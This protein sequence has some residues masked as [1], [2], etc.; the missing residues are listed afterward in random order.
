MHNIIFGLYFFYSVLWLGQPIGAVNGN[1]DYKEYAQVLENHVNQR[2]EV[3]YEKLSS[4]S[5]ELYSFLKVLRELRTAE[6]DAWSEEQK[7]AFWINAYN[8]FTLK[9]II[10]HYPIKSSMIRSISYPKNSIRQIPGVWKKIKFFAMGQEFTLNQIEHNILRENFDEPGIHM[11]LVCAARSCPLLR[12]EPYT[13]ESLEQQLKDQAEKFLSEP[14]NFRIDKQRLIVFLSSIFKWY[15]ED[16]MNSY[17]PKQTLENIDKKKSAV[18]NYISQF[19]SEADLSFLKNGDFRVKYLK[20]D[21][22]LND[23]STR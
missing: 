22:S 3:D 20:Y 9:A 5:S 12:R 15:Q 13:G 18:L 6:Y 14:N 2:G 21:W 10:D 23:S 8:A 11:A 4:D 7:I 1:L 17:A 19:L 16:Y